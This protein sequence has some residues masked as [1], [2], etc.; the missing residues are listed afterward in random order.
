MR[1]GDVTDAFS[2]DVDVTDTVEVRW[3]SEVGDRRCKIVQ[4]S[5]TISNFVQEYSFVA[6][7]IH[8]SI[9]SKILNTN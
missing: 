4:E 1:D 6:V 8:E 2:L 3:Q 9:F 5:K 7:E